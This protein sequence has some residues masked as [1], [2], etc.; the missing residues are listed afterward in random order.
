MNA[1]TRAPSSLRLLLAA[2]AVAFVVDSPCHAQFTPAEP[3]P[4]APAE[5]APDYVEETWKWSIRTETLP[6]WLYSVEES[7]DLVNWTLVPNSYFYGNGTQLKCFICDGPPP[8]AEA[9][10]TNGNGT[11]T[12]GWSWQVNHF[13]LTLRMQEGGASSSYFLQRESADHESPNAW[14]TNLTE[15]LPPQVPGTRNFS[16]LEWADPTTHL[17]YWVDVH[18]TISTDPPPTADPAHP[19]LEADLSIYEQI[20]PQLLARLLTPDDPSSPSNTPSNSKFARVR[21]VAIDSNGNGIQDW[22]EIENF[23]TG[24]QFAPPSSGIYVVGA[25]DADGDGFTNAEE[26]AGNTD[27]NDVAKHPPAFTR[28]VILRKSSTFFS[29]ATTLA[30]RTDY[31]RWPELLNYKE[32]PL[33]MVFPYVTQR[34][35]WYTPTSPQL[36][37]DHVDSELPQFPGTP[38]TSS[39]L[40]S[41]LA[42]VVAKGSF[43]HTP[44]Q[45]YQTWLPRQYADVENAAVW[46]EHKPIETEPVSVTFLMVTR[47]RGANDPPLAQDAWITTGIQT[48]TL[49]VPAKQTGQPGQTLSDTKQDLVPVFPEPPAAGAYSLE[50]E[51]SL[52]PVGLMQCK[53]K[54]NEVSVEEPPIFTDSA[55][56][57]RWRDAAFDPIS[58]HVKDDFIAVDR[59]RIFVRIPKAAHS[60][61]NC[62]VNIQTKWDSGPLNGTVIDE[63]FLGAQI[64]DDYWQT[65]P[66]ILVA[67]ADDDESYNGKAGLGIIHDVSIHDQ[68]IASPAGASIYAKFLLEDAST[69]DELHIARIP[70]PNYKVECKLMLLTQGG[71]VAPLDKKR[72]LESFDTARETWAQIGVDLILI[73]GN[74][75]NPIVTPSEY[76]NA[77]ENNTLAYNT[78]RI[79]QENAPVEGYS[80]GDIQLFFAWVYNQRPPG[81]KTRY[82]FFVPSV[83]LITGHPSGTD[84]LGWAE[85]PGEQA[86]VCLDCPMPGKVL[87][88]EIGH[89]VS[90]SHKQGGGRSWRQNLMG[91]PSEPEGRNY[92]DQKRFDEDEEIQI[93]EYLRSQNH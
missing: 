57:C 39:Y 1:A 81:G 91:V 9:A 62:V 82:V 10:P 71:V 8:P 59:D 25:E 19:P 77:I 54:S 84:A 86:V 13:S 17:L 92:Q 30:T 15:P 85:R 61:A 44:T 69:T 80:V 58:D 38:A 66:F 63:T 35:N 65:E 27:P 76:W 29:D 60:Q 43:D 56:L 53:L 75:V 11:G 49:T 14:Q 90:L 37:S 78:P 48:V 4:M 34:T 23:A 21:R 87:A 68:T 33:G 50:A 18:V 46:L 40:R 72:I 41:T 88:H 24:S 73:E 67:D 16:M 20:K 47:N 12:G 70:R 36:M 6:G 55:R 93:K 83:P 3:P 5:F 52:Q 22:Y 7:P 74:T 42:P 79:I 64:V 2:L 31:I 26:A 89:S 45:V 32:G 51:V 28:L